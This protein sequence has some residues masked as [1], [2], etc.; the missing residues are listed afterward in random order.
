MDKDT[1][2]RAISRTD[3][4]QAYRDSVLMLSALYPGMRRIP[5]HHIHLIMD[6]ASGMTV[7]DVA[8]IHNLR[9]RRVRYVQVKYSEQISQAAAMTDKIDAM[10]CRHSARVAVRKGFEALKELTLDTPTPNAIRL[11]AV[12]AA[13]LYDLSLKLDSKGDDGAQSPGNRE[14]LD[15]KEIKAALSEAREAHRE[16]R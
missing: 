11:L 3:I 2:Q 9:H 14:R 13:I 15:V 1:K 7:G 12:T 4:H 6:L 8:K 16:S 10:Y 5:T